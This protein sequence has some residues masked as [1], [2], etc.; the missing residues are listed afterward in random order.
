M[1]SLVSHW[2]FLFLVASG[3]SSTP[4]SD[5]PLTKPFSM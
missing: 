5:A 2:P 4:P 1:K 3:C